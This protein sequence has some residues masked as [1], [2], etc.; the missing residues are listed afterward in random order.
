MRALHHLGL[1]DLLPQ[2]YGT[3]V[4]P[5]EVAR[6]LAT[7]RRSFVPIHIADFPF[8]ETIEPHDQ[9][10]IARFSD[11]IDIAEA[12]A[13]ALAIEI[14][15]N[16]ILIDELAGR[17]VARSVGLTPIGVAGILIESRRRDLIGK[18]APM[19][20]DLKQNLRFFISEQVVNDALRAVGER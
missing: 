19:F 18:I 10:M 8:V 3:V 2:L 11:Q 4:I 5:P 14:N 6:E 9:E 15:A 13:I 7:P 20:E 1:L 17:S 12:E 16:A